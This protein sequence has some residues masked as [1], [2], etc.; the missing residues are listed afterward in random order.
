MMLPPRG[1]IPTVLQHFLERKQKRAA[2]RWPLA[3]RTDTVSIVAALA[4]AARSD[5]LVKGGT[6]I[7][8]PARLNLRPD[9]NLLMT[10]AVLGA[11]A[12]GEWFEVAT[13]GFLF[14][15]SLALESWSSGRARRAIAALLELAPPVVR[16]IRPNGSEA[17]VAV[18]EVK[19]G[20]RFIVSAG[21]LHRHEKPARA[22]E[23]H[24][25][26]AVLFA[27]VTRI[28]I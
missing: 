27:G 22:G 25:L 3:I 21:K 17:T 4:A 24:L 2:I 19:P 18:A 7:E 12:I 28:R 11:V 15:L 16:I 9:M 26:T 10:I 6:F 20:D 23:P 8:L 1:E 14:A 5:V 13:V